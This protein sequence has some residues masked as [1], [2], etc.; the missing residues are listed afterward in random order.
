MNEQE[1]IERLIVWILLVVSLSVHEWAHAWSAFKLGDDTAAYE[2]RMTF[3]PLAHIDP[4]GTVLLPLLG[5]PFGWARPVPVDPSRFRPGISPATG[6]MITA[7]AGPIS[8]LVLALGALAIF[9]STQRFGD[10]SPDLM[11]SLW[12]VLGQFASL[13]VLL[14]VFNMFPIPP[15]DGSRVAAYLMPRALWPAWEQYVAMGPFVLLA[16]IMLPRIANVNLVAG[17][18]QW[19]LSHLWM[20]VSWLV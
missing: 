2:G 18:Y 5:V 1:I 15:L 9:A 20:L 12:M 11:R 7:I 6:M 10:A 4:I 8:N 3:N 13:N 19:V 17:P 14:A 16:F